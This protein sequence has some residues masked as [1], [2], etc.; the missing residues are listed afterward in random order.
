MGEEKVPGG[1]KLS[2]HPVL[3]Q[4]HHQP[5]N[6]SIIPLLLPSTLGAGAGGFLYLGME[7]KEEFSLQRNKELLSPRALPFHCGF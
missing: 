5:P 4:V 3:Q 1:T 6:F 2:P 7:G